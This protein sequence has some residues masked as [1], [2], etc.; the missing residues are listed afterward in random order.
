MADENT[1]SCLAAAKKAIAMEGNAPCIVNS[2]N[3]AAVALFL[4]KK[5]R[6]LD[7]GRSR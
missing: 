4:K 2:A 3:E 7:I 5:I 6:F 1:F